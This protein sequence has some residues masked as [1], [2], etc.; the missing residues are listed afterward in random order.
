MNNEKLKEA[1]SRKGSIACDE[2]EFNK[3]ALAYNQALEKAATSITQFSKP[4]KPKNQETGN[5]ISRGFSNN[6][7]ATTFRPI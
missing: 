1:Q 3:A 2:N 6:V 7:L 5:V 4:P